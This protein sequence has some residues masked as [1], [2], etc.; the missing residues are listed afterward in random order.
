MNKRLIA[1]LSILTLLLSVP[2]I[3]AKA[4]SYLDC[5]K[6]YKITSTEGTNSKGFPK[7]TAGLNVPG[8]QISSSGKLTISLDVKKSCTSNTFDQWKYADTLKVRPG[9][10]SWV[11]GSGMDMYLDFISY[12]NKDTGDGWITQELVV[13]AKTLTTG[14]KAINDPYYNWCVLNPNSENARVFF[15][16][17]DGGTG[18]GDGY[19]KANSAWQLQNW[20]PQS[21]VPQI[22]NTP[23]F[24]DFDCAGYA[25]KWKESCGKLTSGSVCEGW[26][27]WLFLSGQDTSFSF[28]KNISVAVNKN[29]LPRFNSEVV[30]YEI[31][32]NYQV[33]EAWKGGKIWKFNSD[34]PYIIKRF[35]GNSTTVDLTV[36]SDYL[37]KAGVSLESDY[38]LWFTVVPVTSEGFRGSGDGATVPI[39]YLL[40]NNN[41]KDASPSA[42]PS[43]SS[44]SAPK[45][46]APN[47]TSATQLVYSQII[48]D[49]IKYALLKDKVTYL[50]AKFE[51][52]P[53]LGF[54]ESETYKYCM[55][56]P[57]GGKIKLIKPGK[58]KVTVLLDSDIGNYRA[59]TVTHT[60]NIY[61]KIPKGTITVLKCESSKKY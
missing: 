51:D 42:S 7:V 34:I 33:D 3:P 6:N 25:L 36:I 19:Q 44:S 48:L 5:L 35:Q 4:D 54:Y 16:A 58:C 27:S 57:F 56:D 49:P 31:L 14:T 39:N 41:S 17:I 32:M 26:R 38:D 2:L 10:W 37:K 55:P 50:S 12:S 61:L 60:F 52:G 29:I 23:Y 28:S 40:K 1:F 18:N 46:P 21:D 47:P 24:I 22:I 43:A 9:A 13:S 8:I 20:N 45:T 59:K 11:S 53:K 30:A 15:P